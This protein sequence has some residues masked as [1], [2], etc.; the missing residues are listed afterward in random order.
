MKFIPTSKIDKYSTEILER[1]V[2][3]RGYFFTLDNYTQWYIL[4]T[5]AFRYAKAIILSVRYGFS[6][7]GG[8]NETNIRF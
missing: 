3:C 5:L 7:R 4:F 8:L 2:I 6:V 1:M